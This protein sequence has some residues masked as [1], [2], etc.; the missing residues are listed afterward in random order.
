MTILIIAGTTI[1]ESL[2]NIAAGRPLLRV[3]ALPLVGIA[4]IIVLAQ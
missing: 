4:S 2:L 3:I 1:A